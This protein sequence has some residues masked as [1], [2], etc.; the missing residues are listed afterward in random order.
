MNQKIPKAERRR[1]VVAEAVDGRL[2]WV[3]KLR[4]ADGAKVTQST[5]KLILFSW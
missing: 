1:L 4:I 3:Q 5:R 2:F